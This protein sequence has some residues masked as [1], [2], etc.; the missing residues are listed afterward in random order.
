M[1]TDADETTVGGH[2]NKISG[3]SL[4]SNKAIL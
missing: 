2:K 4:A 1:S 3:R